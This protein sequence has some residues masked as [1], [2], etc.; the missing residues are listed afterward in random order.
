[1]SDCEIYFKFND[2]NEEDRK[3]LE[4]VAFQMIARAKVCSVVPV[5][6]YS[7]PL[8][9]KVFALNP[10]SPSDNKV[11]VISTCYCLK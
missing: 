5:K 1:M 10:L 3:D 6:L 2:S 9:K 4:G 8:Q 11:F 7:C